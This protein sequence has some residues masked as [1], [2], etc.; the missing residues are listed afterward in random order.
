MNIISYDN[1]MC[2]KN[3]ILVLCLPEMGYA[4]EEKRQ[5]AEPVWSCGAG[6]GS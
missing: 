3:R 1:Y 5:T 2:N 4:H 6:P